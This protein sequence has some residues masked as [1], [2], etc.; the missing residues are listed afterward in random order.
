MGFVL[1][2]YVP[3]AHARL[4]GIVASSCNG[5]HGGAEEAELDLS[6]EG[7]L[8]PGQET[9]F[10]LS[11]SAPDIRGAGAY[12]TT[13]GIGQLRALSGESMVVVGGALTHSEPKAAEN[14]SVVFRFAWTAPAEP[15]GVV[16]DVA[17]LAA[18][19]NAN[20]SGDT[21]GRNSFSWAVGCDAQTFYYDGDSDGYGSSVFGVR[22]ACAGQPPEHYAPLDGDCS[23]SR[24]EVNP[25]ADELCN[26]R[27]DDCD[28][29]VDEDALPVELWPDADGDGY[30]RAR[31]GEPVLGCVG[32][33]GY[34]AEP[35]DCAPNDAAIHPGAEEVCN[36]FDD[37]C[38]GRVDERVR[39]Q[40]GE[41]YCRQESYSCDVEDCTPGDPTPERCNLLDDD[42][43][44]EI[45]EG[46]LCDAGLACISGVCLDEAGNSPAGSTGS[47]GPPVAG[48][49]ATPSKGATNG[50]GTGAGGAS[51]IGASGT[52]GANAPSG[53]CSVGG[54]GS[55]GAIGWV[56]LLSIAVG[57][58]RRR[59]CDGRVAGRWGG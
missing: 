14:G 20:S 19:L 49:G 27:D 16:F 59:L 12:I 58:G 23:D 42:C 44:G 4:R 55:T 29:E 37:D 39:P 41:G 43:D 5:C 30:Y 31:E 2:M 22:V 9:V 54:S 47:G 35:G 45:D 34:A 56:F 57:L 15:G 53:G 24:A 33:E 46:E 7:E 50:S 18:N 28:G 13:P 52:G 17:A 40:C 10:S 26:L 25:G 3:S 48:A 51:G 21:P 11:V 32:L 8:S 36:L 6:F 38:N 1:G